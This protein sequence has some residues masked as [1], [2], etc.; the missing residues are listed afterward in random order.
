MATLYNSFGGIIVIV[1]LIIASIIS[2]VY[3]TYTI[4][5]GGIPETLSA[6][7]K[8]QGIL[9]QIAIVLMSLC[10]LPIWVSLSHWYTIP[11]AVVSCFGMVMAAYGTEDK[12]H[13]YIV[14]ST[15][16]SAILWQMIEGLWAVFTI[17]GVLG[18]FMSIIKGKAI[19]WG[20]LAVI[21]SVLYNIWMQI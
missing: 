11:F 20:E 12:N 1:L 9:F 10:V 21:Y 16:A 3:P 19:F 15:C 18:I 2:V 4:R 6:T 7:Y 8:T 17:V 13:C 14:A 5:K